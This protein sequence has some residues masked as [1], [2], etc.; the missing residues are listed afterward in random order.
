MILYNLNIYQYLFAYLYKRS[1]FVYEIINC[2]EMTWKNI[3]NDCS[4]K[5]NFVDEAQ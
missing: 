3:S 2:H 1:A 4:I 5:D